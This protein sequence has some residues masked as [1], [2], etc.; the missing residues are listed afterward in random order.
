MVRKIAIIGNSGGGKTR[1][2]RRLGA[3]HGL[4]VTHVDSIQF[5][6]GLKIRPHVQSIEILD[7]VQTHDAWIIDGYGPL[8]ILEERLA[9]ADK[10]IMID[11][12]FWRH[13]WWCAKRQVQNFWSPRAELPPGCPE[14]SWAQTRRLFKALRNVH[15]KMRPEMIRILQRP[16]HRDKVLWIR[17]VGEWNALHQNGVPG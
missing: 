9:L 2:A 11:F 4:P 8:D 7:E 3:L 16:A 14:T 6:P 15:Q 1:L 5:L 10:I 12:P 13:A 17:T